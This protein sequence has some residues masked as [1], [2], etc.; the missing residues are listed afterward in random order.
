MRCTGDCD[1]NIHL[2]LDVEPR[3]FLHFESTEHHNSNIQGPGL[4]PSTHPGSYFTSCQFLAHVRFFRPQFQVTQAFAI[5]KSGNLVSSPWLGNAICVDWLGN[6]S[7]HS[8]AFAAGNRFVVIGT[9]SRHRYA[10][11]KFKR[12]GLMPGDSQGRAT[13]L[14]VLQFFGMRLLVD[15]YVFARRLCPYRSVPSSYTRSK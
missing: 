10:D 5:A 8:S 13:A 3:S 1:T 12:Y 15:S 6:F 14:V 11:C 4:P 9:T 2:Q 7:I